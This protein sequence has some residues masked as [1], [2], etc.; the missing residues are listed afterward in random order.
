MIRIFFHILYNGIISSLSD[1]VKVHKLMVFF[2]TIHIIDSSS[3]SE[4]E[5]SIIPFGTR[6]SGRAKKIKYKNLGNFQFRTYPKPELKP[7]T[8]P[9][10]RIRHEVRYKPVVIEREPYEPR[11]FEIDTTEKERLPLVVRFRSISS[12]MKLSHSHKSADVPSVQETK[13]E[14]EPH[15]AI[16]EVKKPVIQDIFEYITPY[17]F[18]IREVRPVI[19]IQNTILNERKI[20]V[21]VNDYHKI[22]KDLG[23]N[24]FYLNNY[25]IYD[26]DL[27]SGESV[28]DLNYNSTRSLMSYMNS[29]NLLFNILRKYRD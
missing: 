20:P 12:D 15:I 28:Y 16:Q 6:I 1:I 9:V 22:N 24:C 17:R 13:S 26:R 23:Y 21:D 18:M 3:K 8:V 2:I 5:N 4:N 7:I 14:D 27:Y 19:E 10:Q 29:D 25:G 11:I